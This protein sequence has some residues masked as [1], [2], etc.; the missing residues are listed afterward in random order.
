M[1]FII[2]LS[3]RKE[4]ST[5][6]SKMKWLKTYL[7][8]KVHYVC[9][10]RKI[11]GKGIEKCST[12]ASYKSRKIK[13]YFTVNYCLTRVN[14]VKCVWSGELNY[15]YNVLCKDICTKK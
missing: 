5:K 6:L 13:Q 10:S 9:L 4:N 12:K 3:M 1:R 14:E 11:I 15:K 2:I 7:S 8:T